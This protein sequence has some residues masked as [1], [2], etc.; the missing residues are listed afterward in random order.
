[1]TPDQMKAGIKKMQIEHRHLAEL[2]GIRHEV[3][4]TH[5]RGDSVSV[6]DIAK[7]KNVFTKFGVKIP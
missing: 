4:R 1:M 3:V 6:R 7:I 2:A 5:E